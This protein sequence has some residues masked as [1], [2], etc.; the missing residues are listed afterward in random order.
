[1]SKLSTLNYLINSF[2]AG[3]NE[4]EIQILEITDSS[5]N[6]DQFEFEPSQKSIDVI[7]SFASQYRVMESAK[8]GSVELNLN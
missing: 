8:T 2:N 3:A 1:M 6:N 7:L 4:V 5:K